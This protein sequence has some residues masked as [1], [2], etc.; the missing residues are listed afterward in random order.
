L[1]IPL[2]FSFLKIHCGSLNDETATEENADCQS[3]PCCYNWR[4]THSTPTAMIWKRNI[5]DYR[6]IRWNFNW[7]M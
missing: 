3:Q 7:T 4:R 1:N 6:N 5:W 2:V